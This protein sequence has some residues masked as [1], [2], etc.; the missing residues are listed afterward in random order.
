MVA[1]F[2]NLVEVGHWDLRDPR[3]VTESILGQRQADRVPVHKAITP[4]STASATRRASASLPATTASLALGGAKSYET[5][6]PGYVH[7]PKIGEEFCKQLT[8][9]HLVTRTVKG[10]R[11]DEWEKT[12]ERNEVLDCR[13]YA[14]AAAAV[15]GLDRFGER[16]WRALERHL[17]LREPPGHRSPDG[18]GEQA[19][20]SGGASTIPDDIAF[21][22]YITVADARR[23]IANDVCS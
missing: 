6:P 13:V 20:P 10:Y 7:L 17:G 22:R 8:A 9:E 18:V 2:V 23:C 1:E 19:P 3:S 4:P 16:Q 15:V 21:L 5:Y 11:K 12:R 14:R